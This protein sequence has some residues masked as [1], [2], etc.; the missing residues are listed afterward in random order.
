M[1]LY[2]ISCIYYNM[3]VKV[4]IKHKI[5]LKLIIII[6]IVAVGLAMLF[7]YFK[8]NILPIISTMSE[9]TVRTLA[10]RAINNAAHIVLDTSDNY[11]DLVNIIRDNEGNICLIES[12]TAKINALSRNLANLAEKN[13]ENIQEQTVSV[14]LGAFTGS[15]V[16]AGIGP[17]VDVELLPIGSVVCD[18][19][20]NFEEVGI[21]QTKHSIYINANTTVSIILPVSSVPVTV[22]TS[23][24]VVENII[25]GKVPEFY[26]GSAGDSG[27]L[28]LV[29]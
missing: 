10:V 25:I 24:L 8:S 2:A 23:I 21:N 16:L 29:P 4:A 15:V 22:S 19:V 28:E 14:P 20:S 11:E 3:R 17:T 9:A 27:H 13:V 1:H 26:L 12:N 6:L 7:S 18:F 5:L